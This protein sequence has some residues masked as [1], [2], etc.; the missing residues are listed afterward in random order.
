MDNTTKRISEF[1][2]NKGFNLSDMSRKTGIPYG[3]LYTSLCNE[4]RARDLKADE[5]LKIC[6][7]LEKDPMDF[8]CTEDSVEERR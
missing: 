6:H 5:F 4:A 8:M 3:A 1:V 2:R 7:F